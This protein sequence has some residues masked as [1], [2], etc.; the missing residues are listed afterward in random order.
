MD[1]HASNRGQQQQH[2]HHHHQQQQ[3]QSEPEPPSSSTTNY[4]S[5]SSNNN[6][7]LN[8]RA[9]GADA[10]TKPTY[11]SPSDTIMSPTSKKL[12]QIK[13]RRFAAAKPPQPMLLVAKTTTAPAPAGG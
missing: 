1:P 4:S 9:E 6:K 12:N 5:S 11:T 7:L 2:H 8:S 13:G 10:V 3:P